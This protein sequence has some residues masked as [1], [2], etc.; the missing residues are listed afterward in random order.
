MTNEKM[1]KQIYKEW[2]IFKSENVRFLGYGEPHVPDLDERVF[3]AFCKA[4]M[5]GYF[6]VKKNKQEDRP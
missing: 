4:F 1:A 5:A 3:H 6:S 2:E